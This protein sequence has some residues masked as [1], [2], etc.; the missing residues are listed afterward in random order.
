M[1]VIFS[2]YAGQT[3]NVKRELQR[4]WSGVA[5]I[6]VDSDAPDGPLNLHFEKNNEGDFR[7]QRIS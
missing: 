4:E 6:H 5:R 3:K 2:S 7:L 1:D